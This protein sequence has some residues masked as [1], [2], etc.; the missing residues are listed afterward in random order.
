M[1]TATLKS[2]TF[3]RAANRILVVVE[4]TNGA[5]SFDREFSFA[6]NTTVEAM[7]RT[8]KSYLDE[9]NAAAGNVDALTDLTYTEPTPVEP[10]AAELAKQA[11][12]ENWAKLQKVD[13]LIAAG[14]L[15]GAETAVVTLRNKVKD[16]FKPTYL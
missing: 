11:W 7:K 13:Q 5:D 9:L 10:T 14:V 3:Q 2:K 6:P 12:E 8:A 4:V 15:T 16:D 1:Y